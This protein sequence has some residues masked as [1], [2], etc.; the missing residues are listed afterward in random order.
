[1]RVLS[2]LMGVVMGL[3][4]GLASS[5]R[6]AAAWAVGEAPPAAG[7]EFTPCVLRDV[8]HKARCAV[9]TRPLDPARPYGHLIAIHVA[10]V[11]ARARNTHPDPVFFF[12]GGP[13]Q[14]AIDVAGQVAPAFRRL[15]LQRDLVFVD[16]R[17]T[18]R[19]APLKCPAPSP[20]APLSEADPAAQRQRVQACLAELQRLPHGD[21]RHYTTRVAMQDVEAV[22]LALGYGRINLVGGSYGTRAALEFQRQF[23]SAVRRVVLDG[24]APPDMA[25]P[26]AS[27]ADSQ[28]AFERTLVACEGDPTC[29]THHPQLRSQ[30][31]AL[32]RSLPQQV[33]ATHPFTGERQ[34]LTVTRELLVQAVR[35]PLY[36]PS[37]AAAL[38]QAIQRAAHGQWEAL[39]GLTSALGGA[40]GLEMAEGMHFSVICSE[41]WPRGASGVPTG[42][43]GAASP[44]GEAATSLYQQV[45][46]QW[47]RA[48]VPADFYVLR[49]STVA[50]LLMSGG[51]DPATPPRHGERTA[52]ALG[53]M[54]RHVV[55]PE[56]GHGVM[57]LRCMRDVLHRFIDAADDAAALAVETGCAEKIPR[58]P[59][60]VPVFVPVSAPVFVP[61][62][63]PVPAPQPASGAK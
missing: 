43:A 30:W 15:G 33:Q 16:Q 12:A 37:L 49:P 50:N 54:A 10:V 6:A 63:M 55:V 46:A 14:S 17:G 61:A 4:V 62:S 22:R 58:P 24:L 32:L 9:I 59:V 2:L 29:R 60:F 3:G 48:K 36:R 8:E 27:G 28:A 35:A 51:A 31:A 23:P 21:L 52:A 38:P 11:P 41:D 40:R 26:H 7:A 25:L 18:G 47:P 20:H 34:G 57:G 44:F 53:P 56:A 1:M 5:S 13:G 45:C 19:S 39:L 42:A